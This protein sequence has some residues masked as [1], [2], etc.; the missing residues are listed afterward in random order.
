M[1]KNEKSQSDLIRDVEELRRRVAEL[2]ALEDRRLRAEAALREAEEKSRA[3][4][5]DIEDGYYEVALS[6]KYTS[7]MRLMPKW[8]EHPK[9]RL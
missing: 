8:S 4:L 2:E 6:G 9:N 5:E 3:I 7:V 1:E